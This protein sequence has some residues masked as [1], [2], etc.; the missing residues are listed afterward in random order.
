M[1]RRRHRVW[2]WL[3]LGSLLVYGLLEDGQLCVMEIAQRMEAR[4]IGPDNQQGFRKLYARDQSVAQAVWRDDTECL[5]TIQPG[6]WCTAGSAFT[7][8]PSGRWG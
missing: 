3:G 7:P 1:Q 6:A 8:C 2:W 4:R 5:A